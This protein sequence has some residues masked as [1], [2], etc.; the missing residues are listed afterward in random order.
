MNW[1]RRRTISAVWRSAGRNAMEY[2]YTTQQGD[3]WDIVARNAYGTEMLAGH[4]QE[5]N[6][7]YTRLLYFSA[8]IVLTIPPAPSRGNAESKAPWKRGE[9]LSELPNAVGRQIIPAGLYGSG[10]ENHGD[11]KGR[12][13]PESHPLSAIAWGDRPMDAVMREIFTRL[14]EQKTEIE[15]GM[16]GAAATGQT[17]RFKADG[18]TLTYTLDH[19]LGTRD[20][21]VQAYDDATNSPLSII[22]IVPSTDAIVL[23]TAV[24]LPAGMRVRVA[25]VVAGGIGGG[26]S[27]HFEADGAA[28]T[29][30]LDHKLGTKDLVVQ[31]YDDVTDKTIGIIQTVPKRDAILLKTAVPLPA[32]ARVRVGWRA[33]SILRS[34][35]HCARLH[36]RPYA[37]HQEP[38]SAELRRRDRQRHRHHPDKDDTGRDFAGDGRAAA[39]RDAGACCCCRS[40]GGQSLYFEVDGTAL[41]YTLDHTLGTKNL[42]V[43][44]YDDATDS[45]IGI[46]QI[47][48]TADTI[49]LETAVPLPAGMRVRVAAVAIAEVNS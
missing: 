40:G 48:T 31:A 16:K 36:P 15:E 14:D 12:E 39:G 24:P 25:A 20:L 19:R 34:G 17:L 49:V 3:T 8:G 13:D 33:V 9:L 37:R 2:T 11:L 44:S 29:Y 41:A 43:Q 47:M 45:A 6:P 21:V 38:R 10:V 32:G 22:R 42:V 28:L 26:Q 18:M 1:P 5:A 46:S 23:E 30:A 35:R 7:G 27:L 4:L